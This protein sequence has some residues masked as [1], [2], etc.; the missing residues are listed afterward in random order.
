MRIKRKQ[1]KGKP[2]NII[3]KSKLNKEKWKKKRKKYSK[4]PYLITISV[5]RKNVYLSACNLKGHIK[6]WTNTGCL[7][8]KNKEKTNFF[9]IITTSQL[10]FK[11]LLRYGI[12]DIFIK[13]NG[14]QRARFAI[15]K[16]IKLLKLPKSKRRLVWQEKEYTKMEFN[17]K[18]LK[19]KKV[20]KYIKVTKIKRYTTWAKRKRKVRFLGIWTELNIS[21]NGCR[22]KK[23][24]RKRKRRYKKRIIIKY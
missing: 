20:D 22:K 16:V 7:Q 24:K 1:K 23:L 6:L 8:F 15:R 2:K 10:F 5:L 14:Y 11:N 12:R 9:A 18:Y 19:S 4:Y 17:K 21:F 13:F 3:Q